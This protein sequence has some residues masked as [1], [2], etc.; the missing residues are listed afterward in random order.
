MYWDNRKF[1][2]MSYRLSPVT[3]HLSTFAPSLSPHILSPRLPYNSCSVIALLSSS[4]PL[5]RFHQPPSTTHS[6]TMYRSQSTNPN[7][8]NGCR[9]AKKGCGGR[10]PACDRCVKKGIQCQYPGDDAA[11]ARGLTEATEE[12]KRK[13]SPD[14]PA[15]VAL[16]NQVRRGHLDKVL[17]RNRAGM[18]MEVNPF[19]TS[20]RLETGIT[21]SDNR[22]VE[23]DGSDRAYLSAPNTKSSANTIMTTKA[24]PRTGEQVITSSDG[25]Q[26]DPKYVVHTT[27]EAT[28]VLTAEAAA[29]HKRSQQ[30]AQAMLGLLNANRRPE[31][32]AVIFDD[33]D[34]STLD[35]HALEA[36][37]VASRKV[38]AST[39]L[40]END[41]DWDIRGLKRNE[42]RSL[43]IDIVEMQKTWKKTPELVRALSRLVDVLR[44]FHDFYEHL[45]A[46]MT[47]FTGLNLALDPQ[48]SSTQG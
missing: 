18:S 33:I 25:L 30:Q 38:H 8:C 16:F 10:R 48:S 5:P 24:W 43:I 17:G 46:C 7:L 13:R 31:P 12:R 27:E 11:S 9:K 28:S 36:W 37:K 47:S 34:F 39:N 20:N 14:S 19:F 23:E 40:M 1:V 29:D 4:L 6:S 44:L 42:L 35:F 41:I 26:T 3:C 2:R 45:G 21:S 32:R 22:M 15:Q